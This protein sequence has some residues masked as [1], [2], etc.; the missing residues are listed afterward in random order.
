[1][2]KQSRQPDSARNLQTTKTRANS[3]QYGAE[4]RTTAISQNSFVGRF[5]TTPFSQN[6][7]G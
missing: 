3:G 2:I 1:M 6:A 5:E 7:A 4:T